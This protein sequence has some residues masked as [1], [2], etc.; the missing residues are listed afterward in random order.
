M[1]DTGGAAPSRPTVT[2]DRGRLDAADADAAA[3]AGGP[4]GCRRL[5]GRAAAD[6]RR[7]AAPG[8]G[9]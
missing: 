1:S 6:V 2:E 7:L 3:D 8:A 9:G 5:V 4:A